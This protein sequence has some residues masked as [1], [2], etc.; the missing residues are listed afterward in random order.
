MGGLTVRIDRATCIGTANC[1][2]VAPG[3]FELDGEVLCAFKEGGG[4]P[5][6]EAVIEACS[7]C[8]VDAL[9]VLDEN[10]E[11]LVP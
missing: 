4:A 7:V 5:E 9:E 3:L 11:R 1:I 8:P 10:G 2:R 6:R